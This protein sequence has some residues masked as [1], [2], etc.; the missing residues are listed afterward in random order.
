LKDA[1]YL[2]PTQKTRIATQVK[3]LMAMS[4]DPAKQREILEAARISISLFGADEQSRAERGLSAS[5]TAALA[6]VA[7][8]ADSA[9]FNS[10]ARTESPEIGS[11]RSMVSPQDAYY[12]PQ[13]EGVDA[14]P[15][16]QAVEPA[17]EAA[18]AEKQL[19]DSNIPKDPA[20]EQALSRLKDLSLE[21]RTSVM[22][23]VKS[24]TARGVGAAIIASGI[25]GWLALRA[26]RSQ[27]TDAP[28][29]EPT[30][31]LVPTR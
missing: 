3:N 24:S 27:P 15:R 31:G 9:E 17:V 4:S 13:L 23:Y 5:L 12:S 29:Q 14:M 2:D 28:E 16:I 8:K 30:F 10:L 26:S 1:D 19:V 11:F 7:S 21:D 25:V 22:D 20:L 6:D 18:A